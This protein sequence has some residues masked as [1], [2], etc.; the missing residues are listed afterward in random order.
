MPLHEDSRTLSEFRNIPF[1]ESFSIKR[2]TA[3]VPEASQS[4]AKKFLA[5][6]KIRIENEGATVAKNWDK[7]VPP[8]FLGKSS[9]ENVRAG[10]LYVS[11]ENAAVR[12]EMT[13]EERAILAKVKRLGGCAKIKKIRFV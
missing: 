13:F 6:F 7:C 4:L 11:V 10:V 3:G 5:R 2:T 9:P 1:A 8:R 12:Q